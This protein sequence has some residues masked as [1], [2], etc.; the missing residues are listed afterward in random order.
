MPVEGGATNIAGMRRS[1]SSKSAR[2]TVS[3]ALILWM[4]LALVASTP[5]CADDCSQAESL[6]EDCGDIECDRFQNVPADHC[7]EAVGAYELSCD[8]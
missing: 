2:A 1:K 4:G 5:G 7:T 3:G 6:C 8:S